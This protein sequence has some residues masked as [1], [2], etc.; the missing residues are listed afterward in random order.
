MLLLT[1]CVSNPF[2][3]DQP[4]DLVA[5]AV[6]APVSDPLLAALDS[7]APNHSLR[8]EDGRTASAGAGYH[9]A[10]GRLCRIVTL[11]EPPATLQRRLACIDDGQWHW[12]PYVLP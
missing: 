5:A 9:A 7:L 11:R 1:G 6:V 10:S 3:G 8:L 4:D 2:V 12:Q